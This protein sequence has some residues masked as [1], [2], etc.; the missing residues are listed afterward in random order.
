MNA[1]LLIAITIMMITVLLVAFGIEWR[2]S[3][4]NK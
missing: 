3:K 1:I 4:N 2:K